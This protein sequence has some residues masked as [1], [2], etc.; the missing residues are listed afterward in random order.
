MAS[1]AI[2]ACADTGQPFT[3]ERNTTVDLAFIQA[4]QNQRP[5]KSAAMQRTQVVVVIQSALTCRPPFNAASTIRHQV[6]G[7]AMTIS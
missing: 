5:G 7:V 3:Q 6:F 2:L 4:V 1:G